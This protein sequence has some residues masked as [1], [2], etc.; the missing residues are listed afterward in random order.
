VR[1]NNDA[2]GGTGMTPTPAP[3][4]AT[5]TPAANQAP[6]VVPS[7]GATAINIRAC[8]V[9]DNNGCP[10]IG[11]LQGGEQAQIMGISNDGAGWFLVDAPGGLSGWVSATVVTPVGNT[12]NIPI[13]TP[14]TPIP[15]PPPPPPPPP[16][17]ATPVAPPS[18]GLV[19][20][21]GI[22]IQGGGTPQCGQAFNVEVNVSNVGGSQAGGGT[23][24]LQDVMVDYSVVTFTGYGNYP[25]M[26]PGDNY[27]VVIPATI[28]TYVG[29]K[30]EMTASN[31]G[32]SKKLRYTLGT[33]SCGSPP[34]PQPTPTP[35]Q[36]G[37][38]YKFGP[39]Q[40]TFAL[41]TN[42]KYFD[43]P[44]GNRIGETSSGGYTAV[45]GQRVNDTRWYQIQVGSQYVWIRDRDAVKLQKSCRVF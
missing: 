22:G 23:V 38:I 43:N 34:P 4:A 45:A 14:P 33:G 40:C 39:G 8:A 10:V 20:P 7:G 21:T 18:A 30:H 37:G 29:N 42:V 31:N 15:T 28:T 17:P 13:V 24:T 32:Q 1:V 35:G 3:P 36:S 11:Y 2:A 41:K 26:N 25:A 16:P 5:P 44:N 6:Y 9:I 19:V 12:A 27:V